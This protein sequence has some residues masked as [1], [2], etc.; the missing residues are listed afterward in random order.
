MLIDISFIIFQEQNVRVYHEDLLSVPVYL[1]AERE[2]VVTS[3]DVPCPLP[4]HEWRQAG[5]A[6]FLTM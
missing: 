6:F 5:V 4:H 3:L 1:S 2:T